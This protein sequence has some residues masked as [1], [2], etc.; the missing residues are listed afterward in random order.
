MG[1]LDDGTLAPTAA[2]ASIPFAPEIAIPAV[3]EMHRRYGEHIYSTYGFLDA[4]NPSFEFDVP[5]RQGRIIPGVGWVGPDYLGIDQGPIV[6]MMENHRSE[7]VWRVMRKN[8]HIR[9]GLERAG[10]T[11][12]WLEAE[13]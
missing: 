4:F 7:L 10:F 9:R 2:A 3:I 5:V 12:G 13:P 11:G 1:F 8:P 6:A